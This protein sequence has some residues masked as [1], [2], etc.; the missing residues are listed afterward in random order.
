M[1]F[2]IYCIILHF[3]Q[4]IEFVVFIK[5]VCFGNLISVENSHFNEYSVISGKKDT[6]KVR[7]DL[8][9]RNIRPH[10]WLTQSARNPNKMVKP[11]ALYV[12]SKT[13]FEAF[14]SCI[15][16]LKTPTGY[17]SVL[18]KHLREKNFGGLKS[19]DYYILMQQILPLALRDLMQS[20]PKMAVMRMSKVF[21][22]ICTKVYN[23]ANYASL[24]ADVA[25]SMALVEM[26]FP[27]DFFDIMM[28]YPYH[29]VRE[30]DLCGPVSTR[31]M[32]PIE[33]Y[34]KTLK[35]HVWNMVRP[36]ACMAE[37]YLKDECI[38]FVTEYLQAFDVTQRR[39]WDADE[40]YDAEEV[41]Q[42]GGM[43]FVLTPT[44]RDLA[45]RY[46][47]SN[48]SCMQQDYA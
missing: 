7:Q 36:E 37:G 13:E 3:T 46:V 11:G 9:R 31:W 1:Y 41:L 18:G 42:G 33:R 32:Y 17:Y 35:S 27:P 23:S 10:L 39:V 45:H 22:P 26:E 25:E 44:L 12:L 20:G 5:S 48:I 47:I 30:L 40:E 16:S 8:R 21:R 43:P 2:G 6:V 15:E 24:Q 4:R 29:L 14:V 34:M 19:H 28:H 38:A